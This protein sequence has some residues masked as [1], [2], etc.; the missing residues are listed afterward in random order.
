MT[1]SETLHHDL[2]LRGSPVKASVLC[3]GFINTRI[4]DSAR[5]RQSDA[6]HDPPTPEASVLGASIDVASAAATYPQNLVTIGS[7]VYLIA[8]QEGSGT[9]IRARVRVAD[10]R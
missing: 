8:Y 3:P 2:A 9:K 6:K 7:G 10:L 5:N 4:M 1:L